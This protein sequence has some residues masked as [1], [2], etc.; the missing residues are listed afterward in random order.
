LEEYLQAV[1]GKK[2]AV[3]IE[4][5][6]RE[7]GE[8][9][10][11][12]GFCGEGGWPLVIPLIRRKVEKVRE[13][14]K[15]AEVWEHTPLV[16]WEGMVKIQR[17]VCEF[18]ALEDWGKVGQNIQFDIGVLRRQGWVGEVCGIY[19][20]TLVAHANCVE[21]EFPHDLGFLTSWYTDYPYYKHMGKSI[22]EELWEYNGH[23]CLATIE[24]MGGIDSD[25]ERYG[26]SMFYH[27]YLN[28]L[29]PTLY[30]MNQRGLLVD[31][32]YREELRGEFKRRIEG[33]EKKM[34]EL[35]GGS[36]RNFASPKQVGEYFYGV[37]GYKPY[38]N[39]LGRPTV[40][41]LAL[42]RLGRR[43]NDPLAKTMLEH[44]ELSKMLSTYVNMPIDGD[45]VVRTTYLFAKTGRFRSGR[46]S[47]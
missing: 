26:T 21:P 1:K 5:A 17:L 28:N 40:D 10:V 27:G 29:I 3:D 13:G 9:V 47:E 4:V 45:G 20:D 30:E 43:E 31:K 42:K 41:E 7:K 33:L 37:K 38:L 39:K 34:G 15:K 32:V 44:R 11:C 16:D 24:V 36:I 6:Y 22:N 46:E 2:V 14:R 8:E 12:I 23:D 19:M 25:M 18:F 35:A